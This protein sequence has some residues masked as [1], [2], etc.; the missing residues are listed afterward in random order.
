MATDEV[1]YCSFWVKKGENRKPG[2]L[3]FNIWFPTMLAT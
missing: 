2:F 3:L 1:V